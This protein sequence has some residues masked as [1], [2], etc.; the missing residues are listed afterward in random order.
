MDILGVGP[1]ELIFI[2]LIT[3]I[4]LGPKDMVSAGRTIG[5]FLR[6]IVTS[7]SWTAI[8][9]TSREVRNLPTRL[10][11][12]AGLE[13]MKNQLPTPNQIAEDFDFKSISG[14]M[15]IDSESDQ[16]PSE[17]FD[18]KPDLSAWTT[19]PESS[20]TIPKPLKPDQNNSKN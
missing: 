4:V 12:E 20:S 5:R 1:L 13:E 10:I 11:R 19:S 2:L 14:S 7:P 15:T 16:K 9:Q 18:S 17:D 3:L 6:K 8:Q